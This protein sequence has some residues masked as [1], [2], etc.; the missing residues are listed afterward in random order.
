VGD[1]GTILHYNGTSWSAQT[2]VFTMHLRGV[3]ANICQWSEG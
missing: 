1:L 2:S 3:C